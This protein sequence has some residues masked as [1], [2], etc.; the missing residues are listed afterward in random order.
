MPNMLG[1][2]VEY[3]VNLAEV[4]C[5][6]VTALYTV[7]MPSVEDNEDPFK[8]CD[9]NQVGGHWCPEF[10]LMEANRY[11]FHTTAHKCD[12]PT[13]GVYDNCDRGGTCTLDVLENA[14]A[15]DFLPGSSVGIDTNEEFH[16]KLD[17]EERNGQF[18]GYTLT[19]TQG[20]REVVQSTGDC[21]YLANMTQD[22]TQMVWVFSNWSSDSLD[23]MQHG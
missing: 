20:E 8:Y 22:I 6:S 5:G 19:M 17:F 18:A 10:D 13:N 15:G 1:G 4:P 23:W 2:S 14:T 9:A 16:V 21:S 12:A 3:D 7:L 11:S